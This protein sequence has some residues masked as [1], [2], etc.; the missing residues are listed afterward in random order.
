MIKKVADYIQKH[1]MLHKGEKVLVCVSGGADSMTLL[2][3]LDALRE[4]LSVDLTVVH[5]HHCLR[6]QEADDEA[7]W[8]EEQARKLNLPFYSRKTD[9]AAVAKKTGR[10]LE[11]AARQERYAFFMD[12]KNELQADKIALGHH[13]HDQ[14]ETVLMNFLRGAGSRGLRGMQPFRDGIF[15]RPLLAVSR[16]DIL[17]FLEEKE[18]SFCQDQTNQSTLF[19]RNKVRLDLIPHLKGYNERIEERLIQ[20]ADIMRIEN[21]FLEGQVQGVFAG[22]GVDPNDAEITID[23]LSF[24]RLHEAMQRRA[25]K[26]LLERKYAD[27]NGVGQVHVEAVWN[28]CRGGHV[29]QN[30]DLPWGTHIVRHYENIVFSSPCLLSEGHSE[31]QSQH[32]LAFTYPVSVSH[33]DSDIHIRETGQT[34]R[35][36]LL[37]GAFVPDFSQSRIAWLDY[38]ALRPPLMVRNVRPG[39]HFHPLGAKGKKKLKSFFIDRKIPRQKRNRVLLVTDQD[40]IVW[41]GTMAASEKARVTPATEN[42]LRIEII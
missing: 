37:Q 18:T 24:N 27:H 1:N 14:A 21:D 22:W 41:V 40:D 42:Y 25:I 12:M 6:G 28:L 31:T 26:T 20:M 7:R 10:S 9:V 34:M 5:L 17:L 38:S 39:D 30:L 32:E 11:D 4:E 2:L 35:F 36:T 16:K 15:I 23:L 8:V 19:L 29:G 33:Y 13:L 3:V